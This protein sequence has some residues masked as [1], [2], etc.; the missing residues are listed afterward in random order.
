HLRFS[1]ASGGAAYLQDPALAAHAPALG[2]REVWLLGE[3]RVSQSL[4][5]PHQL[6]EM[7]SRA[8]AEGGYF[9]LRSGAGES[10]HYALFDCGPFGYTHDA[11]HGHADALNLELHAHGQTWIVDPGVYS[12]HLGWEWRKF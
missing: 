7:S 12:T 5:Q 6:G 11:T 9:I 3:A 8:F 4:A 2:E 1:G 10:S